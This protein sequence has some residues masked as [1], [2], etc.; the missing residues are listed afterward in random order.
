[1]IGYWASKL[2]SGKEVEFDPCVRKSGLIEYGV[3]RDMLVYENGNQ[4]SL[5]QKGN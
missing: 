5:H 4:S 2:A 3:A 1:M